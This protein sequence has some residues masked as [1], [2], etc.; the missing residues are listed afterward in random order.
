MAT[1]LLELLGRMEAVGASDLFLNE[2]KPPAAFELVPGRLIIGFE[3]AL[4]G[5]RVGGKRKVVI[6]PAA[7]YGAAGVGGK[8]PPNATLT[9]ELELT[10]VR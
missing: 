10:G 2:G 7:G 3:E 8:I 6:P 4:V 5:M 1:P 9:F